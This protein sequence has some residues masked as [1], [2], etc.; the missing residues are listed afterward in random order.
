MYTHA[1]ELEDS[2]FLFPWLS[3]R[4]SWSR[5]FTVNLYWTCEIQ[6][7]EAACQHFEEIIWLAF[8]IQNW[9]SV[10]VTGV[11]NYW[12]MWFENESANYKI[13]GSGRIAPSI[14]NQKRPQKSFNSFVTLFRREHQSTSYHFSENTW[15]A[16]PFMSKYIP[17]QWTGAA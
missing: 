4:W 2:E 6:S 12:M 9:I 10:N 15:P 7:I 3:L 1:M 16:L 14:S 5:C 17:S 11:F 13:E 8:L